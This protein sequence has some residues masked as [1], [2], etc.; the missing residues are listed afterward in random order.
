MKELVTPDLKNEFFWKMIKTP[1]TSKFHPKQIGQFK[2]PRYP[3]YPQGFCL[4]LAKNSSQSPTIQNYWKKYPQIFTQERSVQNFSQIRPFFKSPGCP[5]VFRQ[6]FSD[7]S[8]IEVENYW[9]SKSSIS[10]FIIR[11]SRT[12]IFLF[13]I[14]SC[15]GSHLRAT[16]L[17]QILGSD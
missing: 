2:S 11:L 8:S 1:S 3:R 12:F 10:N 13:S 6:T 16:F 15:W 5:K 9:L 14:D 7:F 4:V 17:V